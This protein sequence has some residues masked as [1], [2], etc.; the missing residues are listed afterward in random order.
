VFIQLL[1]ESAQWAGPKEESWYGRIVASADRMK[2]L[3][4]DLLSLSLLSKEVARERHGL[5]RIFSD[6]LQELDSQIETTDAMISYSDLPDTN[7][8]PGQIAILFSNLLSNSLKF[9]RP[10]VR[11][12]VKVTHRYIA[13]DDAG[14][15]GFNRTRL[16]EITVADNG[17]GFDNMYNERIFAVF[18]RLHSKEEYEGTGIGL[19]V[20]RKIVKNHGGAISASGVKDG[21]AKFVIVIPA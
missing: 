21:G 4:D 12:E 17:I 2:N 1:G 13:P 7:V 14:N 10:G 20:C 15:F 5:K 11:P 16:L 6:V 3:I 9:T 19:A 18:Q 8:I